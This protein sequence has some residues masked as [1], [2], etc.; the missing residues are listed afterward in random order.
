MRLKFDHDNY[1]CDDFR[2]VYL[3]VFDDFE[4]RKVYVAIIDEFGF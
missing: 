2:W 1:Y 3:L 4:W